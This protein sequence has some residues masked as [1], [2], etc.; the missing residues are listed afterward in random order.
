M[1]GKSPYYLTSGD[2]K[3]FFS[4]RKSA[5]EDDGGTARKPSELCQKTSQKIENDQKNLMATSKSNPSKISRGKNRRDTKNRVHT[6]TG[7]G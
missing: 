1:Q 5:L 6:D 4:S 2:R 3:W 7:K